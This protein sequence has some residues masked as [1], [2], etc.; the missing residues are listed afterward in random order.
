[1]CVFVCVSVHPPDTQHSHRHTCTHKRIGVQFMYD[2]VVGASSG[3][4][5]AD[6]MGLGKTITT[7]SLIWTYARSLALFLCVLC[8]SMRVDACMYVWDDCEVGGSSGCIWADD[9][10]LGNTITTLSLI[11]TCV[12]CSS[13]S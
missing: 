9:M 7:I 8:V 6:D 3:C 5:L 13:L 2:C 4:I 10:G 11:W 12:A 1:M